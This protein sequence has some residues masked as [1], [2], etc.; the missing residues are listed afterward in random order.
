MGWPQQE[1]VIPQAGLFGGAA[2]ARQSSKANIRAHLFLA[3]G[4][5]QPK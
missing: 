5:H 2:P 3:A 1:Q 4:L